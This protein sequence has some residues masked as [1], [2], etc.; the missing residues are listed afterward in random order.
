MVDSK[1]LLLL[2]SRGPKLSRYFSLDYAKGESLNSGPT[3][4][5][6]DMVTEGICELLIWPRK[7]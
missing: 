7:S 5:R 6:H 1:L 2:G 4:P 3:L